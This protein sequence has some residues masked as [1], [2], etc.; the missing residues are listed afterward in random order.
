MLR[1]LTLILFAWTVCAMPAAAHDFKSGDIEIVHPWARATHAS[2]TVAAGY[3]DVVNS[4]RSGDLLTGITTPLAERTEIHRSRIE[5]EVAR[6]RSVESLPLEPGTTLDF[7]AEG[8]HFMFIGIQRPLQA[9]DR[10]PATLFF[11]RAGPVNVEFVVQTSAN[12]ANDH[13]GHGATQ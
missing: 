4:G 2:A 1:R 12:P 8:L 5:G 9:G 11:E 10:F 3:I 6:M 13:A 7:E